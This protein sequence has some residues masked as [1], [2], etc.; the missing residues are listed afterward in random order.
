MND[1]LSISYVLVVEDTKIAEKAVCSVL[2]QLH[3]EIDTAETGDKTLKLAAQN[4]YDVI[5]MDL[6]LPD[7]DGLTLS[8]TI[9]QK[10]GK[11]HKTPIIALTANAMRGDMEKCIEAGCDDYLSKPVR[12]KALLDM[13]DEHYPVPD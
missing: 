2:K 5:F 3:C 8:E 10:D 1:V 12:A 11:N 4:K 9:K 13:V 7:I 6:G